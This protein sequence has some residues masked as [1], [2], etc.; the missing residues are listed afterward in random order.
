MATLRG[1]KINTSMCK[2]LVRELR[3]YEEE[4]AKTAGKEEEGVDPYDEKQQENVLAESRMMIP[5]SHNRLETALSDL[6]ATLAELKESNEH[7][8]E[9]GEAEST[10]TE[11]E[12]AFSNSH[13]SEIPEGI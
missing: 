5:D 7:G 11:V 6:K 9:I 10:I 12:A 4:A 8:A 3:L 2:R 1:L 13:F